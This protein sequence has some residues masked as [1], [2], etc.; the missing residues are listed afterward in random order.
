MPRTRPSYPPAF[1]REAVELI[2]SGTPLKQVAAD[3]GVSEQTPPQLASPAG[4]R[5]RPGRGP[6]DRGSRGAAA[7]A[8]RKQAVAAGARDSQGGRGFLRSGG[9]AIA[10]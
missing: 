10:G 8:A 1:R 5:R 3:L 4:R 7:T 6:D 2:R 9:R